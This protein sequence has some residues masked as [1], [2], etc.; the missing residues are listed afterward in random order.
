MESKNKATKLT[1][2]RS[3][4]AFHGSLSAKKN[5]SLYASATKASTPGYNKSIPRLG[6]TDVK[7]MDLDKK[8]ERFE[9]TRIQ[10]DEKALRD[11]QKMQKRYEEVKNEARQK[12]L[13]TLRR[14]KEY[15]KEMETKG[16][17]EWKRNEDV[18][19]NRVAKEKDFEDRMT[20]AMKKRYLHKEELERVDATEGMKHFELNAQKLGIELEHDPDELNKIEKVD[21][22]QSAMMMKLKEKA[23]Q[24]E[25]ARKEKEKRYIRRYIETLKEIV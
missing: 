6:G 2:P 18:K 23:D 15:I 10:N 12:H 25:L 11:I 17:D 14:N 24:S 16:W 5:Q 13:D 7:P 21:A 22:S 9:L 4:E 8:L 3:P 20:D 19:A 1:A